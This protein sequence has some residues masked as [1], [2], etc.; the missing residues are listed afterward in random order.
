MLVTNDIAPSYRRERMTGAA[1]VR[2]VYSKPYAYVLAVAYLSR[3]KRT[4]QMIAVVAREE[5]HLGPRSAKF[6]ARDT[7]QTYSVVCGFRTSQVRSTRV[8]AGLL[9][10]SDHAPL[11]LFIW[12]FVW[13]IVWEGRYNKVLSHTRKRTVSFSIPRSPMPSTMPSPRAIKSFK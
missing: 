13:G 9:S 11:L 2:E 5:H 10:P 12:G 3:D 4:H 1:Q 6:P 8:R 7:T